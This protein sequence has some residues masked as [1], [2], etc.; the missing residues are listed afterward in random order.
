MIIVLEGRRGVGKTALAEWV[1]A[2]INYNSDVKAVAH[3]F[4]RDSNPYRSMM[5]T[6][7]AFGPEETVHVIDR[8]H[9]SEYVYSAYYS[10][11]PWAKLV[12]QTFDIRSRLLDYRS[13]VCYVYCN[14]KARAERQLGRNKPDEIPY[15]FWA[16]AKELFLPI[17]IDNGT[18]SIGGTAQ[19]IVKKWRK[20]WILCG[21]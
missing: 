5:G 3:K 16:D 12:S 11:I 14:D 13:L 8:F 18:L 20:K 21:S 9:L 10:R 15:K 7:K 19:Q 17:P 6:V 4:E 2:I 1:T